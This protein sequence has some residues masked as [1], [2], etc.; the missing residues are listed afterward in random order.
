VTIHLNKSRRSPNF[1]E[2]RG[3]SAPDM[4]VLHYTA[5]D[6]CEAAAER[7]CDP[8]FEVSAH[9]LIAENGEVHQLVE[10]SKR[11]WH[12][13]R[14]SWGAVDDVNSHSIGIELA[15]TGFHPF[16]EVQ[17]QALETLLAGILERHNIPAQ[18]VIGHSDMAPGRK[19]D[20]GTRFDWQRLARQGLSVWPGPLQARIQVIPDLDAFVSYATTFGYPAKSDPEAALQAFRMRFSPHVEG[21]ASLPD[22][23]RIADL[24]MR[25]PVDPADGAA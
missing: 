17:M 22:L 9:Y 2:R 23:M 12:A 11:A 14:G 19:I 10:E 3:V 7:L 24:A 4:V 8:Q 16:P 13:G 5:M 25:Y 15:N 18:R 6:S 1:G 21:P 20:P